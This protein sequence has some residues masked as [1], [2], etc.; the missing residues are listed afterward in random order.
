MCENTVKDNTDRFV[1][2]NWKSGVVNNQDGRDYEKNRAGAG[3][4]WVVEKIRSSVSDRFNLRCYQ[5]SQWK[6]Q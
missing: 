6:H 1:L 2:S 5:A 4:R 3:D